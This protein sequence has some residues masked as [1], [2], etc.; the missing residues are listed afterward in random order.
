MWCAVF[1]LGGGTRGGV[2]LDWSVQEAMSKDLLKAIRIHLY[3]GG[4]LDLYF[5]P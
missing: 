3:F 1:G 5:C 4:L 2:Q